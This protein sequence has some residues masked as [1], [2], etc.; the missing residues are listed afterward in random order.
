MGNNSTSS[1]DIEQGEP[2]SAPLTL[3]SAEGK[4]HVITRKAALMSM[5]LKEMINEEEDQT[6]EICVPLAAVKSAELAK[7]VEFCEHHCD[8]AL[9]PIEQ[10]LM[11][12][13][14]EDVVPAWDMTFITMEK[15]AL[16]ELINAAN[17][18]DIPSLLLLGCARVAC[19]IK[20]K[21][22]KEIREEFGIN[23][24]ISETEQE[25][26]KDDSKWVK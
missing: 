19:M 7:I 18:M 1:T 13:K 11:S 22:R 8:V 4:K 5:L 12:N 24:E 25:L 14:L 15:E 2:I 6:T 10:P 3:T 21:S 9:P 20:G 17:F 26:L 23:N 16:Y